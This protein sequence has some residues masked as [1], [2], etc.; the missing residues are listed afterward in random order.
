MS[1]RERARLLV[2]GFGAEEQACIDA[3][4]AEAGAPPATRIR[5]NQRS[6]VLGEIIRAAAQE[7]GGGGQSPAQP[8]SGEPP[9]VLFHN[10]TD[11]G[12]TAL[13]GL[14]RQLPVPRPIFAVVT[15]TSIT[16][17]VEE[18]V[19]HLLEEQRAFEARTQG[20]DGASA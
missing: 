10:L 18:L 12:I 7:P 4:L 19:E 15:P 6:L 13:M 17:T 16:W 1:E 9:L 11:A 14:V 20:R 8:G 2:F 5:P 3:A